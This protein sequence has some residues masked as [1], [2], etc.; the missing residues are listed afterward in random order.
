MKV[1]TKDPVSAK[2]FDMPGAAFS[3]ISAVGTAELVIYPGMTVAANV[4]VSAPLPVTWRL[5]ATVGGS[6]TP[7]VTASVGGGYV[8]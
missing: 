1:Q 8:L 3:Q 7:T 6:D 5:V 2:Y 4:S